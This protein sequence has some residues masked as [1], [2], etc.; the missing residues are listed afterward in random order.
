M[1]ALACAATRS[2]AQPRFGSYIRAPCLGEGGAC[3]CASV[4]SLEARRNILVFSCVGGARRVDQHSPDP[5]VRRTFA[6]QG[7]L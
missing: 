2:I 6:Q 4:L 5:H 3:E 7:E 1:L